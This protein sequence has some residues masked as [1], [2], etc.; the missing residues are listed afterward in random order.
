M[1][2]DR[3]HVTVTCFLVA[4]YVLAGDA[5]EGD[6]VLIWPRP[7]ASAGAWEDVGLGV[8]GPPLDFNQ[9]PS[10]SVAAERSRA[11]LVLPL[12]AV[13]SKPLQCIEL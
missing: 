3:E 4:T 7:G 11:S 6:A 2:G 1:D 12:I 13:F 5:G 10:Q 9:Q 8:I